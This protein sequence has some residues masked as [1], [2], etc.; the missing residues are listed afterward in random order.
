VRSYLA[1]Q[2]KAGDQSEAAALSIL[3]SLLGDGVTSYF[4]QRLEFGEKIAVNTGAGYSGMSLDPTTFTLYIVPTEGV[5]LEEAEARLDAA[6]AAF[7]EEG[8]DPAHLERV[9][10]E[11]RASQIYALD[12]QHGRAREYG[13]ALTSGLTVQ[14][15]ADW[16]DVLQAVTAEDVMAAAR[17][18]FVPETS[19]TGYLLKPTPE[20]TQ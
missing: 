16:P 1:P 10:T 14:D 13:A 3:S 18:V 11:I 7:L 5:S 6:V 19:V 2:R 17:A 9:K 4:T 20:A 12:S 15:V 8:V